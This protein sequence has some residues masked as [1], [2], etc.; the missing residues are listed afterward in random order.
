MRIAIMLLALGTVARPPLLQDLPRDAHERIAKYR[1]VLID[2]A[3]VWNGGRDGQSGMG[4]YREDFSGFFHVAL[5]EQWR[6]RSLNATTA[7]AQSRAIYLNAEAY[8]ASGEQRFRTAVERGSA[9]LLAHFWDERGGF[10]W[11]V[12]PDGRPVDRLKRGYGNVHA[13]FALTHAYAVTRNGRY[14]DAA[15]K[16]F[17]VIEKYFT[18]PG[19]PGAIKLNLSEDLT[20]T[21][22]VNNVDVFT[23]YF[24]A[25][26]ALHD[27]TRGEQR[28][29][30][31]RRL[32]QAARFLIDKLYRDEEGFT[33]RGWVAYNYTAEWEPSQQVYTRA[34]QW[35]GAMHATPPHGVELAFLLSRA[36]E[37]GFDASWIVVANKLLRFANVHCI[38]SDTGGFVDEISDFHGRAI[39]GNPDNAVYTWWPQAEAARALLHFMVVRGEDHRF[40]FDRLERFIVTHFVDPLNGG[41]FQQI[42]RSDLQPTDRSK[43]TVWTVGYHETMLYSEI[44]RLGSVYSNRIGQVW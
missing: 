30:V 42:R 11:E 22:G 14:L 34:T 31:T 18:D 44:L 12:A 28:T 3:D 25:L 37:R 7:V 29:R 26:L 13:L 9:F 32:G 2:H 35:S 27:V 40:A 20:T 5:D 41:W 36:V 10:Y 38:D 21:V 43:G 17:E 24:E 6:P 16:A 33:D 23:H 1:S 4:V 19:F 15:W 39:D 8:R